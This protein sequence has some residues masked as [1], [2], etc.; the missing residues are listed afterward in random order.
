[1]RQQSADGLS[2]DEEVAVIVD[3]DGDVE[4]VLKHGPEGHATAEALK[5]TEVADDA[6]RVVRRTGK[7]E[8]DGGRRL[9]AKGFHLGE[10]LHDVGETLR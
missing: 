6:V 1:M 2:I 9:G 10:A 3:E 5:I 4:L 7:R 8:A